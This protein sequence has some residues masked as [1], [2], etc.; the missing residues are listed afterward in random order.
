MFAMTAIADIHTPGRAGTLG[1][2]RDGGD[3]LR[4]VGGMAAGGEPPYKA[5]AR[6]LAADIANGVIPPGGQLPSETELRERHGG[7]ARDTVRAAVAELA[8][9]GLTVTRQ[10][11]GTFVRTYD[12]AP[13]PLAVAVAG[14]EAGVVDVRRAAPPAAVAD[15]L[16]GVT[17]VWWRRAHHNGMITDS[18]YPRD[19]EDLVPDVGEPAALADPDA[20]LQQAGIEVAERRVRL[21]GRI[22]TMAEETLLGTPPGT[23]LEEVT[24]VLVDG[25]GQA[26]AARVGLYPGDRFVIEHTL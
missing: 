23:V 13:V 12:R 4:V 20:L 26:V 7:V 19:L 25:G 5:I 22:P 11:V 3:T 16:P 10:T 17:S 15:L 1:A 2:A 24:V 8:R 14:R 9:L 6:A 21:L 18:Y